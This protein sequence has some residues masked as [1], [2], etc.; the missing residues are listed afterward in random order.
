MKPIPAGL[1]TWVGRLEWLL[2]LA[3]GVYQQPRR[4]SHAGESPDD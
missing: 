2:G 1:T 4:L 3:A